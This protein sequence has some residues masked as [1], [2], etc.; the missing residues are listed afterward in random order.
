MGFYP[1][2][3][4]EFM[5]QFNAVLPMHIIALITRKGCYTP[6]YF[7][8]TNRL[9]VIPMDHTDNRLLQSN[10]YK[11]R[12]DSFDFPILSHC[13]RLDDDVDIILTDEEKDLIDSIAN[14]DGIQQYVEHQGWYDNCYVACTL[15]AE[16]STDN[17]HKVLSKQQLRK[18]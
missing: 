15:D 2:R 14:V 3:G 9:L 17:P 11:E 8:E 13:K 16:I 18:V 7:P 4:V 1:A 6:Q 10:W 12:K 5:F